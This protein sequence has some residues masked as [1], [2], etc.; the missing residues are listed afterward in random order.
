ME[1]KVG[2]KTRGFIESQCKKQTPRSPST[3]L[4]AGHYWGLG[5]QNEIR[6]F[7]WKSAFWMPRSLVVFPYLAPRVLARRFRLSKMRW[8]VPSLGSLPAQVNRSK[9]AALGGYWA[10]KPCRIPEAH[11]PH[12]QPVCTGLPVGW[13][14]SHTSLGQSQGSQTTV[15]RG[16]IIVGC[17]WGRSFARAIQAS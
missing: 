11:S 8:D 10:K 14:A 2:L 9:D 16:Y 4:P 12:A 15:P 6:A 17:T 1:G 3:F 5:C 7:K 13:L